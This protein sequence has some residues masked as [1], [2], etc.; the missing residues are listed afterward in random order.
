MVGDFFRKL[1]FWLLSRRRKG[2]VKVFQ[3][4][5]GKGYFYLNC[6]TRAQI[7]DLY[8][9][10]LYRLL[11][12]L[13]NQASGIAGTEIFSLDDYLDLLVGRMREGFPGD[14]PEAED[15]LDE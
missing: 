9:M 11:L 3:G 5:D 12:S 1:G 15:D 6:D 13:R 4:C 2:C 10:V 14:F 7:L 8:S